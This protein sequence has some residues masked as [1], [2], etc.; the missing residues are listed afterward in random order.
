MD[1]DGQPDLVVGAYR[2]D[3]STGVAYVLLGGGSIGTSAGV[4]DLTDADLRLTGEDP[5]DAAGY[6]VAGVGDVDGDGQD[7]LRCVSHGLEPI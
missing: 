7:D 1:G 5:G 6:S 2:N 4:L 3:S